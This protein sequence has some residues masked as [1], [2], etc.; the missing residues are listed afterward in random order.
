M[1]F[2]VFVSLLLFIPDE[3]VVSFLANLG[4]AFSDGMLFFVSGYI[5]DSIVVWLLIKGD[6]ISICDVSFNPNK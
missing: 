3:I 1:S 4:L 6:L 2:G 5:F